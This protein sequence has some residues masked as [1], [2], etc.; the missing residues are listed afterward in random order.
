MAFQIHVVVLNR[1]C[2]GTSVLLC[3]HDLEQ[4][5]SAFRSEVEIGLSTLVQYASR[6]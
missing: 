3:Y 4:S 1:M 2:R 5:L 6:N